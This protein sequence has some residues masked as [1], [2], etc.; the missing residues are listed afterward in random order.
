MATST[1]S[2]GA[3]KQLFE[4]NLQ[5]REG[6]APFSSPEGKIGG[7]IGSGEGTAD[8]PELR[9]TV[10]WDLYEKSVGDLSCETNFVGVIETDDG[11]EIR[12]DT[13]GFARVLDRSNTDAWTMNLGLKFE[14]D[15]ERYQWLNAVAALW[16]GAFDMGT[17][18]HVHQVYADV[19]Q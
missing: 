8:G 19:K 18:R 6:L 16:L 1:A 3:L 9:G 2:H 4:L 7:Y 17:Y 12:F 13:K 10:R 14:T 11:A 15:D 5:Y